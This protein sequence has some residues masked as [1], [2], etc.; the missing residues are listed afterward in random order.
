MNLNDFSWIEK[1]LGAKYLNEELVQ[2]L[3][4]GYGELKRIYLSNGSSV[5]LKKITY[6]A[7]HDHPRGWST[8]I[9]DER[10]RNSYQIEQNWYEGLSQKL[11]NQT[12]VPALIH[13]QKGDN[14]SL[15]LEDLNASGFDQR[16]RSLNLDGVKKV[17]E[18]LAR[19]HAK[20]IGVEPE[21]LWPIGTY[22]HLDTRPDEFQAMES[23]WLKDNAPKID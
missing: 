11:D 3:W 19:F 8:N 10:K 2:S 12:K 13:N 9:S 20:F 17:L 18:W 15:L 16:Y 14:I 23:S 5:I 7:L 6:P 1:L 21:G 4:S 22:W